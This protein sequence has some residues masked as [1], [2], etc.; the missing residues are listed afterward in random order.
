MILCENM[1]DS[2]LFLAVRF[3]RHFVDPH[4]DG[5]FVIGGLP[6]D[7]AFVICSNNFLLLSQIPTILFYFIFLFYDEDY[8]GRLHP[9]GVPFSGW[10][11]KKGCTWEFHEL[12]YRKGQ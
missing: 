5:T 2:R 3:I 9:K 8:T 12:K 1:T 4:V 6:G 7:G 10:R 11:Y